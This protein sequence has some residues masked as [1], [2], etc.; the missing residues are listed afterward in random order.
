MCILFGQLLLIRTDINHYYYL[1]LSLLSK[2]DNL[3]SPQNHFKEKR[4]RGN[5]SSERLHKRLRSCPTAEGAVDMGHCNV[6]AQG[7]QES[8]VL[9]V[10]TQSRNNKLSRSYRLR[11]QSVSPACPVNSCESGLINHTES[12]SQSLKSSD[13]LQRGKVELK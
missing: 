2:A 5:E 11:Q 4:K 7:A 6:S 9:M 3:S 10:K 8:P 13:V 12:H 1:C